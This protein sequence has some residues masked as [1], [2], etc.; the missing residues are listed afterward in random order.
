MFR[1]DFIYI[2]LYTIFPIFSFNLLILIMYQVK[3]IEVEWTLGY[4]LVEILPHLWKE[5]L[6]LSNN[7]IKT[8][9]GSMVKG[10]VNLGKGIMSIVGNIAKFVRS[11]LFSFLV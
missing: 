11:L 6:M 9:L 8:V 4:A 2:I 7:G 10:V 3:G 1:F 5:D